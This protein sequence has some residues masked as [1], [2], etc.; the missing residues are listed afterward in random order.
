MLEQKC[1]SIFFSMRK[2]FIFCSNYKTEKV[3]KIF[4]GTCSCLCVKKTS[5]S[6]FFST[7]WSYKKT[8][9]FQLIQIIYKRKVIVYLYLKNLVVS[10]PILHKINCFKSSLLD[11]IFRIQTQKQVIAIIPAKRA[12]H[13]L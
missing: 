8:C 13:M 6:E 5:K 11:Q 7:A 12:I 4:Y 10:F 2:N 3:W 1:S 9:F